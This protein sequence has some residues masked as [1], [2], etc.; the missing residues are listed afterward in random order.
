MYVCV[1]ACV[2]LLSLAS[3]AVYLAPFCGLR[4][5]LRTFLWVA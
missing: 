2:H 1:R 5:S 4:E 3:V